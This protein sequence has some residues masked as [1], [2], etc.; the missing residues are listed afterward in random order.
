MRPPCWILFVTCDFIF[1]LDGKEEA[2]EMLSV[3]RKLANPQQ[4]VVGRSRVFLVW[5]ER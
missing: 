3:E 2:S 1:T 5:N 4:L